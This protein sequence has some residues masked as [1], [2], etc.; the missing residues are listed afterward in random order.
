MPTAAEVH[1]ARK[2]CDEVKAHHDDDVDKHLYHQVQVVVIGYEHRENRC[3]SNRCQC[4]Y[5]C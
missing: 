4:N 5:H 3:Q 2:A 1:L